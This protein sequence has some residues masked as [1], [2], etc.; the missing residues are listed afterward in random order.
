MAK[1]DD[2]AYVAYFCPDLDLAERF[3]GDFGMLRTARDGDTLYMRGA[4]PRPYI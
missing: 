4:G 1:I 3:Y 2:I